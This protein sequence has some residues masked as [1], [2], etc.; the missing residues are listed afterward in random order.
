[1]QNP[2]EY[3]A[4]TISRLFSLYFENK[5]S[6]L[7]SNLNESSPIGMIDVTTSFANAVTHSFANLYF[8]ASL[9]KKPGSPE[10]SRPTSGSDCV[11]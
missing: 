7:K 4:K 11:M 6:A 8:K 10:M 2:M 9:A 1:M 3:L 5:E